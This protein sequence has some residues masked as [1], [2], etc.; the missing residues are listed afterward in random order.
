MTTVLVSHS[1]AHSTFQSDEIHCVDPV[2][3]FH[4][5][6]RGVLAPA[7]GEW[8]PI[9]LAMSVNADLES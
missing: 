8:P 4:S 6:M 5:P 2:D 3:A 7:I 9:N 1:H